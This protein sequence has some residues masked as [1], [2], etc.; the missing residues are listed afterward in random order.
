MGKAI[1]KLRLTAHN[2]LIKTGRYVKP[3]NMPRS[4]RI[5]KHCNLN[6]IENEFHFLSQCSPYEA[7]K[8]EKT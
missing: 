7:E 3:K 4:E 2:I 1:C 5:C 8:K 6:I